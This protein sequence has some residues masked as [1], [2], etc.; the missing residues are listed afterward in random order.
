MVEKFSNVYRLK[1]MVFHVKRENLEKY[2]KRIM[3][4]YDEN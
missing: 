1:Y 3:T 4:E 2:G